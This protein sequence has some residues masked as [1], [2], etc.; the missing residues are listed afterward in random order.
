MTTI[1]R[2]AAAAGALMAAPMPGMAGMLQPAERPLESDVTPDSTGGVRPGTAAALDR[3]QVKTILEASGYDN[4][5]DV[6]QAGA[7]F[8]ASA[9]KDGKRVFVRFARSGDIMEETLD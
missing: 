8:T 7:N 5:H 6:K 2:I 4:V 9:I 3:E 1:L